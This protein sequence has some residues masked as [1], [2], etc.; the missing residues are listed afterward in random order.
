[1]SKKGAL[2]CYIRQYIF[3]DSYIMVERDVQYVNRIHI[4]M[5]FS[6]ILLANPSLCAEALTTE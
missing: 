6:N 4:I 1:M 2:L 5:Q 3:A